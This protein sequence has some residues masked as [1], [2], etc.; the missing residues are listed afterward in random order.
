[1][2]CGGGGRCE[3]FVKEKERTRDNYPGPTVPSYWVSGW[4]KENP[5]ILVAERLGAFLGDLPRIVR[6]HS[7]CTLDGF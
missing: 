5:G 1:M 4:A 3:V 6:V 7:L 2:G